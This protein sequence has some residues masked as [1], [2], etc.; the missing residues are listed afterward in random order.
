MKTATEPRMLCPSEALATII[1]LLTR[2]RGDLRLSCRSIGGYGHEQ[3]SLPHGTTEI[4]VHLLELLS[5]DFEIRAEVVTRT[6]ANGPPS[7]LPAAFVVWRP[8]HRF[9]AAIEHKRIVLPEEQNRIREAL[10][11]APIPPSI[12]IDAGHEVVG[13][14][15]LDHPADCTRDLAAVRALLASMARTLDADLAAA[16]GFADMSVP[17][18]G[19]VRNWGAT[20]PLTMI[21]VYDVG[22]GPYTISALQSAFAKED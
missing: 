17:L 6:A 14:W 18:A 13:L 1:P 15:P 7:D 20:P 5:D 19:V 8:K 2:G 16:E 11:R 10:A 22:G 4:P 9:D 3:P 12:L 21:A